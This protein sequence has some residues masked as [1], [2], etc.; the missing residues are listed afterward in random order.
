MSEKTVTIYGTS[1]DLIEVEGDIQAECIGDQ[2]LLAF[3]DGTVLSVVYNSDGVWSISRLS[4][5]T[6][7]MTHTPADGADSD[8]YSDR[9]TLTGDIR[10]CVFGDEIA[11][12]RA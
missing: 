8:N 12:A 9:V 11:R 2:A 1:D 5:G 7:Q 10:W 4:G 6:A 3:S